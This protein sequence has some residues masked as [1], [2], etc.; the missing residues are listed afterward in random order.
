MIVAQ[1]ATS[2]A[3][4]TYTINAGKGTYAGPAYQAAKHIIKLAGYYKDIEPYLPE[5]IIDKYRTKAIKK[6]K[7][8]YSTYLAGSAFQT[9]KF[10]RK[11][12][13]RAKLATCRFNQKCQIP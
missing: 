4:K 12:S 6:T 5:N 8:S 9:Q 11:I 1:N 10:K 3:P 2:V 13:S 7:Y